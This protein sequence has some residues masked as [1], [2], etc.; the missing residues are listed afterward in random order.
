MIRNLVPVTRETEQG[1]R[2]V[3]YIGPI[4]LGQLGNKGSFH[5]NAQPS[6]GIPEGAGDNLGSHGKGLPEDDVITEQSQEMARAGSA[7]VC[8]HTGSSFPYLG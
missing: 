2:H 4:T 8:H 6:G 7:Y 5:G 3:A 1:Y